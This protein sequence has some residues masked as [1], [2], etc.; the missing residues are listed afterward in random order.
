[1][2]YIGN[3]REFQSVFAAAKVV[4]LDIIDCILY[5]MEFFYPIVVRVIFTM[6]LYVGAKVMILREY[7]DAIFESPIG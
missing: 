4:S 6:Y 2:R 5:D 7:I 3:G 1:M